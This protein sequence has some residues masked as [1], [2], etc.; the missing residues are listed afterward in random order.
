MTLLFVPVQSSAVHAHRV[1]RDIL[2]RHVEAFAGAV[3][4]IG[5]SDLP[6]GVVLSPPGAEPEDVAAEATLVRAG[7]WRPAGITS[8][9]PAYYLDGWDLAVAAMLRARG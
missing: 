6:S 5:R 3:A 9:G 1:T 7:L 2:G 4:R 8:A